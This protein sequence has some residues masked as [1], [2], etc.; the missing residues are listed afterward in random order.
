MHW[1]VQLATWRQR[2]CNSSVAVRLDPS[3][4]RSV[5]VEAQVPGPP[6]RVWA[7]IATAPG[8]SAWFA[9]TTF[10]L[11]PDGTPH[12]TTFSFAPNSTDAVTVTAWEPPRRFVVESPNF[13][14]GGPSVTTKWNVHDDSDGTC[15]LRVEH[16]TVADSDEWD[17]YLEGAE[18]GWPAFFENLTSHLASTREIPD[19]PV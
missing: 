1:K 14:S 18:S 5:R 15:Q 8:I 9:P 2:A 11:G 7:A 16:R 13:I 3:G 4:H 10:E 12:R 6:D 19:T 17:A